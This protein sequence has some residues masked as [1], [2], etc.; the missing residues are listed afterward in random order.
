HVRPCLGRH[1]P[2]EGEA[3]PAWREVLAGAD[4][5]RDAAEPAGEVRLA[6][7]HPADGGVVEVDPAAA[8]S[9]EYDVVPRVDEDHRGH[10]QA[11]RLGGGHAPGADLDAVQV[12]G[13]LEAGAG[14][15]VPADAAALPDLVHGDAQAVVG[16]DDGQARGAAV[17]VL[18]LRPALRAHR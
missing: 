5:Q 1:R 17:G 4:H 2:G 14:Q 8:Y 13:D 3:R 18:H 9:F 12:G 15:P 10:G 6:Q 16:Q 11:G 7:T